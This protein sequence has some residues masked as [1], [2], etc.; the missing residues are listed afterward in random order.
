MVIKDS[1]SGTH[2]DQDSVFLIAGV[3]Y[4][5]IANL[6]KILKYMVEVFVMYEG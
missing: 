6:L 3:P 1:T 5:S 4:K 2:L